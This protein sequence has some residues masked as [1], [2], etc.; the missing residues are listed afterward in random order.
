M[1][2]RKRR[3]EREEKG[4]E[5]ENKIL[6]RIKYETSIGAK[7]RARDDIPI[8]GYR[9][10]R[11]HL[12]FSTFSFSLVLFLLFSLNLAPPQTA[13][14]VSILAYSVRTRSMKI[15]AVE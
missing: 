5:A 12:L 9:A 6:E 13:S 3:K 15:S 11:L 8:P 2:K 14:V 1:V 7:L 4:N 10:A